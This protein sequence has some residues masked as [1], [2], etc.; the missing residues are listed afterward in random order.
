MP[1]TIP[2]ITP[3]ATTYASLI[4]HKTGEIHTV[5]I[6]ANPSTNTTE[7]YTPFSFLPNHGIS[8]V[9]S[10]EEKKSTSS[11][12]ASSTDSFDSVR[13]MKIEMSGEVQGRRVYLSK[14]ERVA[15]RFGVW[16]REQREF[17]NMVG[18]VMVF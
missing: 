10:S 12:A 16:R 7:T 3:S 11:S 8:S 4:N 15:A 9:Y 2:T 5:R 17:W 18:P 6:V 1:S 14:R 13:E